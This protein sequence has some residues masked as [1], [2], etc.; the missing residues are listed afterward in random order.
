MLSLAPAESNG[1]AK[2]TRLVYLLPVYDADSAEHT[3]HIYGFLE[4]LAEKADV[5]LIIERA[6]NRPDFHRVRVYVQR[7]HIPV[8]SKLEI[9]AVV[10]WAH[11]RGY[12]TFYTHYSNSAAILSAL[13]TRILGG[14]SY[15]WNCGHPMDFVPARVGSLA[16]LKVKFRNQHLLGLTLRLV[17][18]LVTGTA[19]ITGS[20]SPLFA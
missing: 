10:L 20:H 7:L 8:L 1:S 14:V 9:L 17:H 4:S 11:L 3:F 15:Y 16:D 5:L 12:R 6:C 18:H 2:K 13:V 19:K